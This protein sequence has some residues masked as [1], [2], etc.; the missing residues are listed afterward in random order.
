MNFTCI[1]LGIVFLIAG[2]MFA[3][4]KVHIY[5]SFWSNMSL[6]EK[7]KIKIIPLCHNI[8]A[9]ITLSGVIFLMRDFLSVLAKN[10]FVAAMIAWLIIAMIDV[11]YI[12]NSER[13]TSQ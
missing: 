12:Q 13:Y 5:M 11:W 7:E 2:C 10:G 9:V 8:G 4:G 1:F 6:E 3:Y